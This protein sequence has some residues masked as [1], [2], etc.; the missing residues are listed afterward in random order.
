MNWGV[1]MF[2]AVLILAE[3]YYDL[4]GHEEFKP[5]MRKAD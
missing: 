5:K 3:V 1:L 2:A 4:K